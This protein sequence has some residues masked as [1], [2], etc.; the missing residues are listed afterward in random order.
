MEKISFGVYAKDATIRPDNY[1]RL[2]V[3]LD[4][5]DIPDLLESI[6]DDEAILQAIGAEHIGEW[7][8]GQAKT[9]EILEELDEQEIAEYL[10][11]KGWRMKD[12]SDG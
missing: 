12:E 8:N 11:T 5:I 1:N 3:E 4:G 10:E 7:I 2:R 6:A 9:S